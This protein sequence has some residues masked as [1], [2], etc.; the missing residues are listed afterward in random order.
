MWS[1]QDFLKTVYIVYLILA[2]FL[3]AALTGSIGTI[4]TKETGLCVSEVFSF[5]FMLL[6]ILHILAYI[7]FAVLL[8]NVQ[9]TLTLKVKD[10]LQFVRS[11][12][13]N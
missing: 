2:T 1:R 8:R 13:A 6:G 7:V 3:C 11:L 12:R 5:V 4:Y 9:E 10:Q